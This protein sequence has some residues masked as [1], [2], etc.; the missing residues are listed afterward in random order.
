MELSPAS[1]ELEKCS[2]TQLSLYPAPAWSS[3]YLGWSWQ[4]SPLQI[5]G[6]QRGLGA[7]FCMLY[8]FC[9]L[10][11]TFSRRFGLNSIDSTNES[12]YRLKNKKKKET[13][14]LPFPGSNRSSKAPQRKD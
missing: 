9:R 7:P 6:S 2:R 14:L 8:A 10:L 11:K 3:C 4:P 1:R 12:V 5:S 13:R